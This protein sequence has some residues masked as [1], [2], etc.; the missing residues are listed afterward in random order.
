MRIRKPRTR[1]SNPTKARRM[2]RKR[3]SKAPSGQDP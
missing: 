2:I 1:K 3:T